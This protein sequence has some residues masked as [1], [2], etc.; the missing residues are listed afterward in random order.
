MDHS[1]LDRA[2]FIEWLRTCL[3]LIVCYVRTQFFRAWFEVR[4]TQKDR[5]AHDL[6]IISTSIL[7]LNTPVPGCLKSL[8]Y[9]RSITLSS[10]IAISGSGSASRFTVHFVMQKPIKADSFIGSKFRAGPNTVLYN[11][12][13]AFRD[14]YSLKAN[15]KKSQNYEAWK[16]NEED[17]TVLNTTDVA[18]HAKRR[19]ILNTVFTDKLVRSAAAFIIKHVDRWNEL[20]LESSDDDWSKPTDMSR[21]TECLVL[22]IMSDLCFGKSVNVKEPGENPFK[23]VPDGIALWLKVFNPVRFLSCQIYNH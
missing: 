5:W 2:H 7:W 4:L 20:S 16:R 1:K 6:C 13:G 21:W 8:Q 18:A 10:K 9:L 19:R 22:D 23:A 12:S 15:V 17:R 3:L 14:I 11:S